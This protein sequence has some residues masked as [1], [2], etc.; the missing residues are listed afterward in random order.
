MT[1]N[2]NLDPRINAYRP[3]LA[4]VSV[5]P[6]VIATQYVEPVLYQCVRGVLPLY[7]KPD[8]QSRRLSEARYGEF[9]DVFE[10]RRDGFAWVQNRSDRFVG[11]ARHEGTLSQE[12][13]ALM[14]RI[15]VHHTFVYAEPNPSSA[16][17]DHLTLGSFVSLDGVAGEFYPLTSGGYIFQKHVAPSDEV[18]NTDYVTTAGQLLNVPYLSGG[19]TPLGIDN[20]ALVQLSL[21]LAG[22]D[23]PRAV[24]HQREL[25]GLPLP[26][27]WRDVVWHRGDIVFFTNPDHVGIM[28]CHDH[29]ISATTAHMM[30]TVE[31]LEQLMARGH[32]LVAAGRP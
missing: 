16:V 24:D 20:A 21:D 27:H 26:C 7:E 3:D 22:I 25:F 18:A 8:T 31:P 11:Y 13:A 10:V 19:R 14:N 30:V 17:L 23:A 2:S 12:I 1:E 15:S 29:I 9:L 5:K 6:L 4:S 32:V 28:T